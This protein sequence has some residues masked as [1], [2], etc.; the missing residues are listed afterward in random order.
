[1]TEM[2]VYLKVRKRVDELVRERDRLVGRLEELDKVVEKGL[3]SLK[4]KDVNKYARKLEED[5]D[6]L[7]KAWEEWTLAFEKKLREDP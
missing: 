3:K 1:M 6:D 7:S 2:E 4:V 5:W